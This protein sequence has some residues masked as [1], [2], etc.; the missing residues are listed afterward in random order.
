MGME[1]EK[2]DQAILTLEAMVGEVLV[3]EE[4]TIISNRV[5]GIVSLSQMFVH[6][7]SYSEMNICSF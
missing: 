6:F 2:E 3:A 1:A 7:Y 5:R 4:D